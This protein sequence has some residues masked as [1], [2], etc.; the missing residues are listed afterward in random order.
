MLVFIR[1]SNYNYFFLGRYIRPFLYPCPCSRPSIP[2]RMSIHA[3]PC[4][5]PYPSIP[6]HAHV[7][8]CLATIAFTLEL[9]AAWRSTLL[10]PNDGEEE[11]PHKVP[12][13][14]C[15]FVPCWPCVVVSIIIVQL[16]GGVFFGMCVHTIW[17]QLDVS[18]LS[19]PGQSLWAGTS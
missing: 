8:P 17:G 5:C 14:H 4:P 13:S 19:E 18:S 15:H 7:H 10:E 11:P 6:I 16:F 1:L 12:L 2:I 9:D 3:H